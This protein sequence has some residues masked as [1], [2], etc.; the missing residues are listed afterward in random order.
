MDYSISSA[1]LA[2]VRAHAAGS[3]DEVCGLLLG[4]SRHVAAALP[5]INVATDPARL[6]EIDPVALLHAQRHAREG[7]QSVLGHY[8][9]HPSGEA[10]PSPTDARLAIDDGVL[11][12][13]VTSASTSAWVSAASGSIEG[14]F[15]PIALSIV[16]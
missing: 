7:G 9:S 12:L 5:T 11:W 6:F 16:P 15:D 13:I 4:S 14:R 1:V 3:I 8:H 2:Q 10:V